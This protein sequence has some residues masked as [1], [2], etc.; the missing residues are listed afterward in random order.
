MKLG[1]FLALFVVE[2]IPEIGYDAMVLEYQYG[3]KK[4]PLLILLLIYSLL[5]VLG[6]FIIIFVILKIKLLDTLASYVPI[7]SLSQSLTHLH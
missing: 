6:T 2:K 5:S 7:L 3:I 4:T 1:F